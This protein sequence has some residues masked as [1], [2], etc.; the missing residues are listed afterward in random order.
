MRP[1]LLE[2]FKLV[3]V[4]MGWVLL[5]S[6]PFGIFSALYRS[7]I[8]DHL[9]SGFIYFGQATPNF[10]LGIMLILLFAVKLK[11]FPS[12][13][14]GSVRHMVLPSIALGIA[15]V[16]RVVRFVRSEMIGVLQQDYIRTAK[17]KGLT[18]RR[19]IL[20]HSFRNVLIPLVTDMGLQYGWLFANAVV[21]EMVFA[22]PGIGWITVQAIS[23][24]DY[25]L[26]QASVLL[27][28]SIFILLTALV[29][30]AYQYIDP[31]IRF[32]NYAA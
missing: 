17:S 11:L 22:W 9:F 3:T 30:I 15:L 7:S 12:F 16:A 28:I 25:P 27:L 24:R 13:G 1:P 31:L 4:T 10:W 32:D 20:V 8:W 5:L 29:D 26:L 19:V 18:R 23:S 14:G 2:T 6:I 21:I